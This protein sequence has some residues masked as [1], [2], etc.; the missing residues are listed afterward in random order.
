MQLSKAEK[1]IGALSAKNE[2]FADSTISCWIRKEAMMDIYIFTKTVTSSDEL[3]SDYSKMRDNIAISFQSQMLDK[4]VERWNIYI[5]FFVEGKVEDDHKLIIEQDKF[6]SRKIV[7]DDT[8]NPSD[9]EVMKIIDLELFDFTT[10]KHAVQGVGL[11]E[12]L[13]KDYPKVFGAYLAFK[14]RENKITAN[15]L[16]DFFG[17]G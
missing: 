14:G 3:V 2:F 5:F 16:I 1:I 9:D 12:L 6:S 11:E 8:A 4:D 7:V 10:H 15:E 13:A 17:N